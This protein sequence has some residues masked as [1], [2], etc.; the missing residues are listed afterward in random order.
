MLNPIK[1]KR[2]DKILIAVAWPYASGYLH[3]GHLAPFLSADITARFFR[4]RKDQV[5]MVSGSDM[6]GTPITVKADNEGIKP[7]EVAKKYHKAIKNLFKDLNLSYDNYTSTA[8]RNHKEIVQQFF[9]KLLENKYIF[10]DETLQAYCENDKK[11]LPDRYI[12]G[13]CPFCGFINA[14][15]D[16]CDECGRT[17][18]PTELIDP[19]CKFCG[20]KPV[21]RP[22]EHY[23]LDL[24]LFQKR[25]ADYIEKR[26]NWRPEVKEFSLAWLREGLK[27]RSITRDLK[28]G[29]PVPVDGFKD[30]VIYVWFDAVIGYY[31]A[32]MEWGKL[33][34][35]EKVADEY[36]HTNAK[37]YYF[38]GK[39]NIPFHTI[40]L[41]SILMGYG[42]LTLPYDVVGNEFLTFYGKQMSKSRN[43]IVEAQSTVTKYGPDG[44]RFYMAS[45]MPE[46]HDTD[47]TWDSFEKTNNNELVANIGNFINRTLTF[48]DKNF[49]SKVPL[50][51]MD[52][53]IEKNINKTF[54]LVEN[55]YKNIRIT[56]AVKDILS[57]GKVANKYFDT[58][59]PWKT[60]KTDPKNA[61]DVIF[62]CIQVISAIN[63]LLYP[64]LPNGCSEIAKVFNRSEDDF[65]FHKVKAGSP[66]KDVK[67][68]FPKIDTTKE[69]LP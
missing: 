4:L 54:D 51:K 67:I 44:L 68:F 45:H 39:D 52:K 56:Q 9:L 42:G 63:T 34:K 20:Q 55:D 3:L 24:P 27:P 40:I 11:F 38:L 61:G 12:E 60:V 22:T 29:I 43:W 31:S 21:F 65:S 17:L 14:R 47:F 16:Q 53:E 50:G 25:L 10:K 7:I 23:F 59:K 36:W 46:N 41:P 49:E 69:I 1:L 37:H 18:D 19:K 62:N 8:T 32:T 35:K 15:G 6:H 57:L 58:N 28:Y 48:T 26:K 64:I 30:K 5:L 33:N 66:I 2:K 13:I